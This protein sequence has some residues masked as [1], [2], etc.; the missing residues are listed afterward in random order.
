VIVAA[1]ADLDA[2]IP[3]LAKGGSYHAGRVCVSVQRVFA[4]R[5]ITVEVAAHLAE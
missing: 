2:A 3:K 1:D 4:Q 5:A